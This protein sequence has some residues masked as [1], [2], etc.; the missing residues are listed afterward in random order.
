[1]LYRDVLALT[2]ALYLFWL[3]DEGSFINVCAPTCPQDVSGLGGFSD[4]K[5][6]DSKEYFMHNCIV[7]K[8]YMGVN[9]HK[10]QL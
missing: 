5:K 3:S 9:M 2:A 6:K 1:M 7:Y 4:E 8:Y 10:I